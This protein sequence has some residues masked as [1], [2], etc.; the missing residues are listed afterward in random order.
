[1]Y[2][3]AHETQ[4]F[5]PTSAH[6]PPYSHPTRSSPPTKS[7]RQATPDS[8]RQGRVRLEGAHEAV[9]GRGRPLVISTNSRRVA[10]DEVGDHAPK[11]DAAVVVEVRPVP[12]GEVVRLRG[13]LP[14][15]VDVGERGLV[16]V[17][18]GR[19]R[20]LGRR[21]GREALVVQRVGRVVGGCEDAPREGRREE[22]G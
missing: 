8:M 21:D 20:R 1:M 9:V 16:Q 13:R 5:P 17:D 6:H 10:Q 18:V 4:Q 7:S 15:G 11:D 14:D 2:T 22:L 12:L 3:N 19:R